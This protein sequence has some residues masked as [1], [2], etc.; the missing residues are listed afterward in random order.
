[1]KMLAIE[2]DFHF[3][4]YGDMNRIIAFLSV[5]AKRFNFAL[6]EFTGQPLILPNRSAS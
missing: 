2:A 5:A 4:S 6:E 1:M 3:F